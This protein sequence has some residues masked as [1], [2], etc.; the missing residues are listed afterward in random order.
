MRKT[1]KFIYAYKIEWPEELGLEDL[2]TS[3]PAESKFDN[4]E[5]GNDHELSLI[6][7]GDDDQGEI[8]FFSLEKASN[9]NTSVSDF[10]E[11]VDIPNFIPENKKIKKNGLLA[12]VKEGN[13]LLTLFNHE[14]FA[15]STGALINYI[16]RKKGKDLTIK[17][18]PKQE[19]LGRYMKRMIKGAKHVHITKARM[20]YKKF[21][22]KEKGS[23]GKKLKKYAESDVQIYKLQRISGLPET[24]VMAWIREQMGKKPDKIVVDTANQGEV[25]ILG[26]IYLREL[27]SVKV[28]KDGLA[29]VEDFKSEAKRVATKND[30]FFD[31]YL[32]S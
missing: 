4:F 12:F 32:A 19:N 7:L 8:S 25:D 21:E 23:S 28:D 16:K 13:I 18:I 30:S 22:N 3:F 11:R 15:H 31:Q 29:L 17:I 2:K 26:E 24:F 20:N 10:E 1:N 5:T 6:Y 14:A 9:Y 27:C